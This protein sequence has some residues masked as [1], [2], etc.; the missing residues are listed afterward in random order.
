MAILYIGL[1]YCFIFLLMW[2]LEDIQLDDWL[3]LLSCWTALV[4]LKE[5]GNCHQRRQTSFSVLGFA[6]ANCKVL[7]KS[8]ELAEPSVGHSIRR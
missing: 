8:L 4:S 7:D 1:F 6:P 5:L 3:V 2:P